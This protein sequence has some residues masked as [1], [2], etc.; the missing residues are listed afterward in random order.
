MPIRIQETEGK[1]L[2][3]RDATVNT[4]VTTPTL[5]ARAGIRGGLVAKDFGGVPAYD[6][7]LQHPDRTAGVACLGVPFS[8]VP[9]SFETTMPEGFYVLRWGVRAA[10][11]AAAVK[12]W[13]PVFISL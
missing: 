10:A 6:F 13:Q 1:R 9:F 2:S 5:H 4:S 7:A 8:P 11:A 12:L 3:R